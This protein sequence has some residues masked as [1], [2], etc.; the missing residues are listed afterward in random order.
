MTCPLDAIYAGSSDTGGCHILSEQPCPVGCYLGRR[1]SLSIC[2][3][4]GF[5]SIQQEE[6]IIGED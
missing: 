2:L 6:L 5:A 3:G 4:L 1:T